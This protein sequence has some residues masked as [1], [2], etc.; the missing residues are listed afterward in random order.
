MVEYDFPGVNF[1]EGSLDFTSKR[2]RMLHGPFFTQ[3]F[4][5]VDRH[6]ALVTWTL[7]THAFSGVD[8]H[9]ALPLQ[10]KP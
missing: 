4:S 7:F 8:R 1:T 5:V 9:F 10:S 3:A 6:F 2:C